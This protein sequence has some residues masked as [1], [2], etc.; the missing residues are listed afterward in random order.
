VT[1]CPALAS[2]F[3]CRE[4]GRLMFK[5]ET[6]TQPASQAKS[7]QTSK[8]ECGPGIDH[9]GTAL[10]VVATDQRANPWLTRS[11]VVPPTKD[12][13]QS[14]RH[15]RTSENSIPGRASPIT[16]RRRRRARPNSIRSLDLAHQCRTGS[17]PSGL[18]HGQGLSV[19]ALSTD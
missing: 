2:R 9:R 5:P 11:A 15:S 4:Q 12:G 1:R 17:L 14:A 19:N 7:V 16:G 8:P 18:S 10:H 6:P 3:F 13:R